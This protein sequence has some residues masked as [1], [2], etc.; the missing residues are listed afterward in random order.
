MWQPGRVKE[1]H[2][3]VVNNIATDVKGMTTGGQSLLKPDCQDW[4]EKVRDI[5]G[6]LGRKTLQS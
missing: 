3:K 1:K 6:D 4:L 5:I 2:T